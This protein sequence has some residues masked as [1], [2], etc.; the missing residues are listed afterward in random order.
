MIR[1]GKIRPKHPGTH[2]R[3]DFL[4]TRFLT[5]G[6]LAIQ[7]KT[8]VNEL[9]LFVEGKKDVDKDFAK[10]LG[11]AL[12]TGPELWLKLQDNYDQHGRHSAIKND[13]M[14]MSNPGK[15]VSFHKKWEPF[16]QDSS[17]GG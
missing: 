9:K 16:T 13:F 14:E 5:I 17:V 4:R 3:D 7:M 6:Q 8:H 12:E 1:Q 10:Q 11:K 2:L 15:K